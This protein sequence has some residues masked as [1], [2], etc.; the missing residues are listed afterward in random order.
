MS[1]KNRQWFTQLFIIP[2]YFRACPRCYV[3]ALTACHCAH[4]LQT[5]INFPNRTILNSP[6]IIHCR[7]LCS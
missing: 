6:A 5:F 4:R 3:E 2:N 7:I 1:I